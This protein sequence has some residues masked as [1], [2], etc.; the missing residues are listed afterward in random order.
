MTPPLAAELEQIEGWQA[1]FNQV[2]AR[3]RPHTARSRTHDQMRL[4]LEGVLGKAERRNGWH[5]AEAAGDQSPYA[6]Q[7]LLGRSSWDVEGVREETRRYVRE[8][9]GRASCRERV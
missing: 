4:Y 5:L 1:E 7:H 3:L 2:H 8:G 9:I 6:M